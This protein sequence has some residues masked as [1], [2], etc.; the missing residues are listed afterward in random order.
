MAK[1]DH[2]PVE[3]H[4]YLRAWRRSKRLTL[5]RVAELIGSK[6]N[7]ISGWETGARGVGLDDLKR[8]AAAYGCHP[9]ALLFPPEKEQEYASMRKAADILAALTPEA[10]QEWLSIGERISRS[11]KVG[12]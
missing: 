8:L 5:E 4:T 3:L 9:A 10:A 2:Q 12:S 11:E 6:N 7:T 1:N